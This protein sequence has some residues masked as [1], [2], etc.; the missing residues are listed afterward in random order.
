MST[1]AGTSVTPHVTK[2]WLAWEDD[3]SIRSRVLAEELGAEYYAFTLLSNSKAFAW[4]RYPVAM[5]QTAWTILRR[6]PDLVVAQNPSIVLAW[7]AAVLKKVLGYRLAI[8]LHTHFVD[9]TGLSKRIYDFFHGYSLRHCDVVIVTNDAYRAEIAR[10]TPAAVMVLPDKVPEFDGARGEVALEGEHRVL[11]ICTFA[12]DEP[13]AEVLAAAES[14]PDDT[15]I[16]ISGRSPLTQEQVPQNVALTGYLP[17]QDYEDLLHSVDAVMVLTTADDN[18]VCGGYEAVAAGK[19]LILSDTPALR[20]FFRQGTVY[21][22]NDR[23]AIA[24][25]I[26]RVRS[27]ASELTTA[28]ETLREQMSASW[29][30]RWRELLETLGL[31][32]S[33]A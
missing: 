13:W 12:T 19:P 2:L 6:R 25:S 32:K 16:Y 17:R 28:I 21:T 11:Y 22:G 15:R 31:P 23:M 29:R 33:E 30:E 14:L 26:Q 10:Q 9:P 18:L 8:D 24:R 3:T 7:E 4:L 20:M 5:V 1:T 27:E